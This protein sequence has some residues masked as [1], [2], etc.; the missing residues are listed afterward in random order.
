MKL[1]LQ[2][3]ADTS[4][5]LPD[6][7]SA[8]SLAQEGGHSELEELLE[9]AGCPCGHRP[10]Q[11]R[12][13]RAA[14]VVVEVG[15]TVEPGAVLKAGSDQTTCPPPGLEPALPTASF[16]MLHLLAFPCVPGLWLRLEQWS[17][18]EL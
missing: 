12:T 18:Q 7:S 6:G 3:G 2:R 16:R 13:S 5:L 15:A 1:L 10:H 14:G 4:L 9:A 17:G 8:L 11:P